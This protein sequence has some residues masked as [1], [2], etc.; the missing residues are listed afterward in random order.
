LGW[1]KLAEMP[2]P[3]IAY[4]KTMQP[5]DLAGPIRTPNGFH[6]IKLIEIRGLGNTSAPQHSQT[7]TQAH[8]RQILIKTNPLL[9]DDQL[10]DR[11]TNVRDDIIAGEDFAKAAE[12]DSQDPN[13]ATHG[14][15]LGWVAP[16]DLPAE[17]DAVV[18]QLKLNQISQP[19]KSAQGWY[20]IEVIGRRQ[21]TLSN[22][23]YLTAEIRQM[24][25][26]RKF[27]EAI[28]NW[29]SQLRGQS[30]IKIVGENTPSTGSSS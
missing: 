1:R 21:Q 27:N 17:L 30:Y 8:V 15:D 26:K 5:G 2:D 4:V 19:I 14:G 9:T 10:K 7:I 16:G 28:Q 3:F 11:A 20:L 29:V 13:T 6:I 12:I 23:D 22:K 18:P 25:Y 24:I